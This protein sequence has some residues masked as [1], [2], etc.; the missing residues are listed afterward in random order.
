MLENGTV[1]PDFTLPDQNGNDFT[2]SAHRGEIVVLYFYPRDNTPGCTRE[3]CSFN[4]ELDQFRGLNA[5]VVGVS[6]DSAA[7]HQKFI[8]RYNLGFTLLTDAGHDVMTSYH[9]YG[10]KLMYGKK[11]VGVVRSTYLIGRDGTILR[12]WNKVNTATHAKVVMK[13]LEEAEKGQN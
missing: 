9:A 10:E 8:A 1:A 4:D 12:S 11:T 2:L 6:A 5:T 13:A 3:A 7:S